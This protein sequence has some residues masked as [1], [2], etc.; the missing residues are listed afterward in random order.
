VSGF[1]QHHRRIE[2]FAD[3]G[4]A[5]RAATAVGS[6]GTAMLF[7]ELLKGRIALLPCGASTSN[8][9]VK[10]FISGTVGRPTIILA[11][12][13]DGC[14]LGPDSWPAAGRVRDWA[15]WALVHGAGFERWHYELA[16]AAVQMHS[17]V[18]IVE[19]SAK[20]VAAWER[21]TRS[22]RDPLPGLAI[23]PRGAHPLPEKPGVVQ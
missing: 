7:A 23:R 19:C 8:G 5:I 9:Q 11:G 20:T 6:T 10:Q 18:L 1:H 12:F 16:L 17:R 22:G 15:R 2:S 13:D 4:D 3:L 21:F 14:D